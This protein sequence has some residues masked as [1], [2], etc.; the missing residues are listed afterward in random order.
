M[1]ALNNPDSALENLCNSA[2]ERRLG[3]ISGLP[4]EL[5]EYVLKVYHKFVPCYLNMLRQRDNKPAGWTP[6]TLSIDPELT[7]GMQH[8]F[9]DYQHITKEFCRVN[10]NMD[11][12]R[13][14]DNDSQH[15][16]YQHTIDEIVQGLPSAVKPGDEYENT[17]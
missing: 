6:E 14:I 9:S 13:E 10:Q 11:R 5:V 16:L 2:I 17:G 8:F 4:T 15:N 7:E 3:D 12:L 1:T